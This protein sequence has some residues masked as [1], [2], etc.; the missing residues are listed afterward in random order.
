MKYDALSLSF[1]GDKYLG[2]PYSEM[3]CQKFVEKCMAD[4]GFHK[5]LAGSNAWYREC[6]RN[7]WTGT[8]EECV[9]KYGGVPK[10]AL[11]FI[12]AF[13]GGEEK[14]GYH[15]GLGN[16]SH[17]GIK[18]GR[19]DGAIHSSASRKCVA[20]S[21]FKDKTIPNGGWN[22]VG[23]LNYFNYGNIVNWVDKHEGIG[24]EPQKEENKMIDVVIKS[25]NGGIVFLRTKPSKSS[26]WIEKI[27]SGSRAKMIGGKEGWNQIQWEGRTGWVM[28]DFV[29]GDDD[30]LPAEDPE[31]FDQ[32]DLDDTQDDTQGEEDANELLAE[33]YRDLKDLCDRIESL[34][35]RG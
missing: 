26:K 31:D 27:P 14:R 8:P 20:T 10:G 19:N 18:T 1:A 6:I 13:D 3:D 2:T 11:L 7:G 21:T 35:G 30:D 22:R 28:S 16:A 29:F 34:I 5:D 15:D 17:I 23:L 9:R 24:E 33:V 4:C 25:E 12:H 32:A